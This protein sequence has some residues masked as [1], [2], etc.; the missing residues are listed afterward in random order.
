MFGTV[1]IVDFGTE[2]WQLE[3]CRRALVMAPNQG[4]APVTNRELER[5]VARLQ[6]AEAEVRRLRD[7]S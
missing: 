5:L 2:W 3:S 1:P 4:Q 6:E 7:S